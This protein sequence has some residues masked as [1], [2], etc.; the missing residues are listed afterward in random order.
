MPKKLIGRFCFSLLFIL[1]NL[2]FFG[3]ADAIVDV[4]CAGFEISVGGHDADLSGYSS[5]AIQIALGAIKT[6]ETKLTMIVSMVAGVVVCICSGLK[7]AW[8]KMLSLKTST[9]IPSVGR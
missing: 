1:E 9:A 6:M 3:Q 4:K 2:N 7:I 8:W 5:S